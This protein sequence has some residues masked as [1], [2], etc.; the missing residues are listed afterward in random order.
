ML[1][2]RRGL[3]IVR[4]VGD[5]EKKSERRKLACAKFGPIKGG[6]DEMIGENNG[7]SFGMRISKFIDPMNKKV[8]QCVDWI[9]C[10][11]KN[12]WWNRWKVEMLVFG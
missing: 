10:A 6:S 8:R 1:P 7:G 9:K 12:G 4:C 2:R 5:W 11:D 3:N